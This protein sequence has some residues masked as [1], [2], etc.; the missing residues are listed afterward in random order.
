MEPFGLKNQ[1]PAED[2]DLYPII[3]IGRSHT[4]IVASAPM[5]P[6]EGSVFPTMVVMHGTIFL[7]RAFAVDWYR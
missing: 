4:K 1:P 5:L 3:C 6:T 2:V 7:T